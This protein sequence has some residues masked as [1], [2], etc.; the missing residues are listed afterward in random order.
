MYAIRSYYERGGIEADVT[1]TRLADDLFLVVSLGSSQTR[2][3]AWFKR[4]IPDDAHVV[5]TDITSGL[6]MLGVMGP[7]ARALLEMLSGEDLSSAAFPFATSREIEIGCVR[8][9]A[10]RVTYVGE[11]GWELYSYNFV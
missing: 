9:Q 10:S 2:D 1:V 5:V 7:N 4:Q 8:L 11:L 6:P 3:M